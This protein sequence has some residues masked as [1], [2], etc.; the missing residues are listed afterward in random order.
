M[1]KVNK[2]KQYSTDF[3]PTQE[4]SALLLATGQSV[5]MVA[6]YLHID[7]GTL[8]NW[9][10]MPEYKTM[11]LD[12][13]KELYQQTREKLFDIYLMSVQVI[14]DSLNSEDEAVRVKIAM[15]LLNDLKFLLKKDIIY[16]LRGEVSRVLGD[17]QNSQEGL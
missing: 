1:E 12:L 9:L 15:W 17:T 3:T 2:Y 8:Y 16:L 13:R 14:Q 6:K 4:K 7:R 11:M 10:N 5:T